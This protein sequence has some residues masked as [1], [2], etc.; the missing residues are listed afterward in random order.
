MRPEIASRKIESFGKRFGPSRGHLYLAYHAAFPLALTPDLLYRI[1]ANF[2]Q[3]SQ[4]KRLKIRWIAVADLLLSNLCDEVGHELYEMDVAVRN[5]LLKRL[6]ED[7]RFGEKRIKELSN[8]LLAYV[9]KDLSSSEPDK[10]DF[11]ESQQWTALAYK[12]PKQ[13]AQ[14]L[15]EAFKK[16]YNQDRA[17][18]V[19]LATL[20]EI[21]AQPVEEFEKLLIY[22]RAMGHYARKRLEEAKK[23]VS[24]LQE[25]GRLVS[26]SGV[27]LPIPLELMANAE[28]EEELTTLE[29]IPDIE[30]VVGGC[31]HSDSSSYIK[32]KADDELYN[33]IKAG[34]FCRIYA[35]RQMGKS[36][37]LLKVMNCL[38][39]E[40]F[41]CAYID[42]SM[43]GSGVDKNSFQNFCYSLID[44]LVSEFALT[45]R[46]NLR[47]WWEEETKW[48]SAG[49]SFRQFIDDILTEE[50]NQDI[51]IF[52][53]EIDYLIA[54]DFTADFLSLLRGLYERNKF[55]QNNKLKCNFVLSGINLDTYS[56]LIV[57]TSPVNVGVRIELKEFT[58]E[59]AV[60]LAGGLAE[61]TDNPQELLKYIL[62]WTGGQPFLTQKLCS[63]VKESE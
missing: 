54:Q 29:T 27:Y 11:A 46:F 57:N 53:D 43:F 49:M 8:F 40:R 30:Y 14:K 10:R 7:A 23:E 56:R 17:E 24:S 35:P 33:A 36:S 13:A 26:I 52:I 42:L 21:L 5:E 9:R 37:L 15:A 59:E 41:A 6:K 62:E 1:W 63:L 2:Q 20:T 28:V 48:S 50:I 3:D 38:K 12:D 51:I 34:I 60:A 4:K 47:E 22:A 61:K 45:S 55:K 31:L 19:R 58:Y 25:N 18:L 44:T 32:R 39:N 16:A